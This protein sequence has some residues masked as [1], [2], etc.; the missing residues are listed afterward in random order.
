MNLRISQRILLVPVCVFG[1]NTPRENRLDSLLAWQGRAFAVGAFAGLSVKAVGPVL[2]LP[3]VVVGISRIP[4]GRRTSA[5]I[6][7]GTGIPASKIVNFESVKASRH[8]E[9]LLRN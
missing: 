2:F 3:D 6:P 8:G 9:T 7:V 4:T 5:F 1:P